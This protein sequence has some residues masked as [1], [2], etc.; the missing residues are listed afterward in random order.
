MRSRASDS[1]NRRN[2]KSRLDSSTMSMKSMT[3]MP[4]ISRSRS[5]RTISSAASRLFLVTVCSRLPPAP[6]NLPVLTSM[7]VMASVRSI[8]SV[9]PDGNHTLRSIALAS[10]SSMRCT[11]KTSGADWPS[12]PSADSY[13]VNFE[14]NSGATEFTYSLIVFQA[15]SPETMRPTKSSLNRSRITLTS[16]SGSSYSATAAPAAFSLV[17]CALASIC[18]QRSRSRATS[19]R[20][21]SS[22]TPSDAVRMMTPAS[23]GTTSRRISLSR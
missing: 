1:V 9:P 7:T 23:D 21:S 5:W 20:M 11:V 2:T 19:A 10:C 6:V 14:T 22:L 8:T 13:L 4:P 18:S 16:T 15:S 12:G 3:T 17:S